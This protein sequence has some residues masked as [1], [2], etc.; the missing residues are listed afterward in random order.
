MLYSSGKEI[1]WAKIRKEWQKMG[2]TVAENFAVKITVSSE[3]TPLMS[4]FKAKTTLLLW[5]IG[6]NSVSTSFIKEGQDEIYIRRSRCRYST[7]Y[8]SIKIVTGGNQPEP[9]DFHFA[10]KRGAAMMKSAILVVNKGCCLSWD[11]KMAAKLDYKTPYLANSANCLGSLKS[12]PGRPPGGIFFPV[13]YSVKSGDW[14]NS[15]CWAF[16]S[17]AASPWHVQE[18]KHK[19]KM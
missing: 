15:S 8:F 10:L 3:Q 2:S 12:I 14:F 18:K 19:W 11:F 4:N 1:K 16:F 13:M 6:Q 9:R 5:K 17:S 7:L